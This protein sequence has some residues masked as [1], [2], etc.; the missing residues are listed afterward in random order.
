M[1]ME[2]GIG[3]L[4]FL[5]DSQLDDHGSRHLVRLEPFVLQHIKVGICLKY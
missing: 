4:P 1:V 3:I 2:E 5:R